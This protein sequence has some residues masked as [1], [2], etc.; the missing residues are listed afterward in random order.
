MKL[1]EP[2][3]T[4][5]R[6]KSAD[7]LVEQQ[8]LEPSFSNRFVKL[9]EGHGVY[10]LSFSDALFALAS[11][12][13]PG[14]LEKSAT[15]LQM[16]V[17]KV[18]QRMDRIRTTRD[19]IKYGLAKAVDPEAELPQLSASQI[20]LEIGQQAR[21]L[22]KEKFALISAVFTSMGFP[23]EKAAVVEAMQRAVPD[24]FDRVKKRPYVEIQDE[25]QEDV[26]IVPALA[27]LLG[28][29]TEGQVDQFNR[30]F[31]SMWKESLAKRLESLAED[32]DP[33][34]DTSWIDRTL[35]L[36]LSLEILEASRAYIDQDGNPVVEKAGSL[37][38]PLKPLPERPDL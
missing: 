15:D 30:E 9:L 1:R 21:Q 11:T 23:E 37:T 29:L 8:D 20:P 17:V 24:L 3:R 14:L 34:E 13:N 19:T 38:K 16:N 2:R 7:L 36:A 25:P 4:G 28:L 31:L 33:I 27:R 6:L 12:A 26:V 5:E 10:E 32:R 18:V 22:H 35:S